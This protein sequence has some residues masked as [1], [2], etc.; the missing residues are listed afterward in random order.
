[1][2][3]VRFLIAIEELICKADIEIVG[4]AVLS[5]HIFLFGV[6]LVVV[7]FDVAE[8]LFIVVILVDVLLVSDPVGDVPFDVAAGTEWS[9]YQGVPYHRRGNQ[10][11]WE[12]LG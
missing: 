8:D 1:M 4:D 10:V 3:G 6:E 9:A 2:V 12:F 7:F 11:H 5:F